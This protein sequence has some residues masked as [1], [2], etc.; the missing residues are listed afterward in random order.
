MHSRSLAV[1]LVALIFGVSPLF[2]EDAASLRLQ[3]E[4]ATKLED[5]RSALEILRR[6]VLAAPNDARA[7]SALVGAYLAENDPDRAAQA[8]ESAAKAT[9]PPALATLEE[10]RGDI[11]AARNKPDDALAA[12]KRALA[13]NRSLSTSALFHKKMAGLGESFQRW[14]IAVDAL[15]KVTI[16]LTGKDSAE[17]RAKLAL[18]LL[19]TGAFDAAA[20]EM[21][22]AGKLDASVPLVK[23]NL[24]RF[25]DLQRKLPAITAVAVAGSAKEAGLDARADY[26]V[27]LASWDANALALATIE[28]VAK[29]DPSARSAQV[30]R[31]HLLRKFK[32]FDEANALRVAALPDEVRFYNKLFPV[33]RTTDTVLRAKREA[34]ALARRA[35]N[36]LAAGQPLLALED[37]NTALVLEAKSGPGALIAG[38]ASSQLGRRAEALRLARLAAENS[39][40]DNEAWNFVAQ[41]QRRRTEYAAAVTSF[42]QAIALNARDVDSLKGR[43][44]CLRTLGREAEAEADRQAWER[45]SAPTPPLG[46]RS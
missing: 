24:P 8:L 6:L 7:L 20:K 18:A 17:P 29:T 37:A 2:A 38:Q 41:L 12:W 10:L 21:L 30:L 23:S 44:A 22:A 39:P 35:A 14:D 25:E 40:R 42:G 3:L 4:T 46:K 5:P 9:P 1:S 32:R 34:P 27:M 33:L 36:L 16:I 31:A 28:S 11:A 45:L 13:A 15:R 43:E 19:Q 26:A